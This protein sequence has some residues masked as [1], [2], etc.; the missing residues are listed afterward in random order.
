[1][2]TTNGFVPPLRRF[3]RSNNKDWTPTRLPNT[4]LSSANWHDLDGSIYCSMIVGSVSRILN[5]SFSSTDSQHINHRPSKNIY[6]RVS[7]IM[8]HAVTSTIDP[9]RVWIITY[10][11][12]SRRD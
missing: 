11:L 10:H 4:A 3:A 7:S 2:I 1:M 9:K 6:G 12:I 5:H 8:N